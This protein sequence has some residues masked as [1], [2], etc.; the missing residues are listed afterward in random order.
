MGRHRTQIVVV[1]IET[2]GGLPFG[3][4]DFSLGHAGGDCANHAGSYL[5]LQLKDVLKCSVILVCPQM[6]AGGRIDQLTRYPDAIAGFP[7]APLKNIPDPQ[8]PSH[9]L[10]IDSSALERETG[11]PSDHEKLFVSRKG[12]DDFFDHSI[13]EVFLLRIASHVLERQHRDGRFVGE[14]EG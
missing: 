10:D 13:G 3:T 9:L 14:R 4:I 8:I 2:A 1:R 11:V 6:R 5:I 7:N 12:G